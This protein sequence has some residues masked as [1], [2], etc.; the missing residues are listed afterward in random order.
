MAT[1]KALRQ[2]CALRNDRWQMQVSEQGVSFIL[3][4][5]CQAQRHTAPQSGLSLSVTKSPGE[6]DSGPRV[7]PVPSEGT[8]NQRDRAGL[9]G[10]GRWGSVGQSMC[11]GRELSHRGPL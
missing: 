5:V 4:Y 11:R 2:K 6:V 10:A 1:A 7:Y 8:C 3:L 9:L